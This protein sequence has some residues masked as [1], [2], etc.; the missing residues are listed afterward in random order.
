MSAAKRRHVVHAATWASARAIS[1]PVASPSVRAD[2]TSRMDSQSIGSMGD[3]VV[4]RV[5]LVPGRAS[6]K[7]DLGHGAVIAK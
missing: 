3:P 5:E 1:S 7:T 2:N 4:G 6:G